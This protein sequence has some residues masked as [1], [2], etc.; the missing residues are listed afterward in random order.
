MHIIVCLILMGQALLFINI[1][2]KEY[3]SLKCVLHTEDKQLQ[4]DLSDLGDGRDYI[5]RGAAR[6]LAEE[7]QLLDRLHRRFA[8]I[9]QKVL[10]WQYLLLHVQHKRQG[11]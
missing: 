3:I 6:I 8:E 2:I 7:E 9:C 11:Q 1:K 4:T 10:S 5:N